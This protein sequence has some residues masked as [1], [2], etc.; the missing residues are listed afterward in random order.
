MSGTVNLALI[1][2]GRIARMQ[3]APALAVADGV[4]LWSVLSRSRER[5]A[6][7]AERHDAKSSVAAHTSLDAL[8]S[9]LDLDGIIIATPDKLHAQQ[10]I[11]AVRAGKHVLVEK[12]MATSL[13][14]A[15]RM[16]EVSDEAG[17]RLGVA[18]HLRWHGGHRLVAD[19]VQSGKLGDIR[20]MRV[21]WSWRAPD[22]SNWRA[23]PE[24]GRWW[25]LAGVGTHCL[26]LIRWLMVPTC[27]EVEQVKSVLSNAVWRGPHDESAVV[28]LRFESGATAEFCS[29]VNFESPHRLEIYGSE[30]Y[31]ICT[32]TLGARGA[33]TIEMLHR[34]LEF[35][36][37]NPY[38]GEMLDFAAAIR[39]ERAPEVDGREGRR[40][41]ELLLEMV[42][43]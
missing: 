29:S 21:Q 2:T 6:D 12:P 20:H 10:C 32:D 9:D 14:D 39:D 3:L 38:V 34:G 41:V 35:S 40:N 28:V 22:A 27:G 26:D 7:F 23:R 24:V 1:G 11:T 13:D 43:D 5:A 33:G 16:I 4:R 17:V 18:Y 37:A 19:A 42:D 36:V 31:A 8:V 30:G 25:S 15:D